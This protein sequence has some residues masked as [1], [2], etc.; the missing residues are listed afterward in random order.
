ML[1]LSLTELITSSALFVTLPLVV[2]I[3][4]GPGLVSTAVTWPG[5]GR[6]LLSAHMTL[7]RVCYGVVVPDLAMT[8][9]VALTE[10]RPRLLL[11][12]VFFPFLRVLDAAIGL[13]AIP[14]AWLVTSTRTTSSPTLTAGRPTPETGRAADGRREMHAQLSRE[15]QAAHGPPAR[16]WSVARPSP[17]PPSVDVRAKPTVPH[18]VPRP[19]FPCAYLHRRGG[20][21]GSRWAP[22]YGLRACFTVLPCPD[23]CRVSCERA[24]GSG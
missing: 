1:A 17:R 4:L 21:S 10:R 8:C 19:R 13:Q 11:S 5:Y 2:L 14:R 22:F 24:A 7:R 16:T 12:A 18:T 3:L 15:R 23:C 6:V 20:S 9:V